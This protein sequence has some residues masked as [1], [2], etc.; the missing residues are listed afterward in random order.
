MMYALHPGW[1]TSKYDGD[2]HYIGVAQLARLYKLRHDEYVIWYDDE[3]NP[4]KHDDYIHLYPS[5]HGSYG[6]PGE[7]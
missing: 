4:L 3:L 2:Q 7:S 1:I 5:Y 6:R